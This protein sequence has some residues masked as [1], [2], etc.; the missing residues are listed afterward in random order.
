MMKGHSGPGVQDLQRILNQMGAN[1]PLAEDGLF[2]PKTEA[3]LVAFQTSAGAPNPNGRFGRDSLLAVQT[4]RA[5]WPEGGFDYRKYESATGK[6]GGPRPP[7]PGGP[8]HEGGG[9]R[10]ASGA[11]AQQHPRGRTPHCL[12][13]HPNPPDN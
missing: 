12:S 11:A 3:A 10:A 2:G 7:P 13:S 1:P 8:P 4:N 5:F 9:A 6:G